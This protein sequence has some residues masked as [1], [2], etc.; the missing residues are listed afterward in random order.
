MA[1]GVCVAGG[2]AGEERG[3][4]MSR[5]MGESIEAADYRERGGWSR[6]LWRDAPSEPPPS[7]PFDIWDIHDVGE[8]VDEGAE[9]DGWLDNGWKV[10]E[11]DR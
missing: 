3:G 10:L 11:G 9:E 7:E 5:D 1:E 2:R 6:T 8:M 4:E